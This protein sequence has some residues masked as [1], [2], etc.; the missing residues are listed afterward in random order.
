MKAEEQQAGANQ[1]N[2][3]DK[4]RNVFTALFLTAG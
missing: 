2:E 4:A 1:E 3:S